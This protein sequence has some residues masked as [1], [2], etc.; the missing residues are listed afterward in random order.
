MRIIYLLLAL[1]VPTSSYAK[2]RVVTSSPDL[3]ALAQEVGGPEIE[4]DVL[5]KGSQNLHFLETKPSYM[6]KLNK[7]DLFI[8]NGLGL[9]VGWLAAVIQGARNP[10]I[11]V[12]QPGFLDLGA[13]I[14][15][16]EISAGT[17]SR[18][19]GDVHPD[20]NPHWT[21]D[22]IRAGVAADLISQKMGE[23]DSAHATLYGQRS[24]ALKK[25][26]AQKTTQW[27]KRIEATQIRKVVTY[28]K[29]LNYFLLRFGLEAVDYLEPK[30]GIPPSAQ[31]TLELINKIKVQK[32]P[33]ILIENFYDD[34]SAER[35]AKAV[36]SV[37]VRQVAAAV[38]ATPHVATLDDLYEQLVRAIESGDKP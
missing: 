36:K 3:G 24:T 4:L 29:T 17:I 30:P 12:G 23:L 14:T 27:Q 5:A 35:I 19:D 6:L 8:I 25:R 34:K 16:I 37:R 28:H 20:G 15:P 31:H 22:P 2:I 1:S 38:T 13:H 26:L 21:L 32:I 7:A 18:A 9:E 11:K 10:K 33:L